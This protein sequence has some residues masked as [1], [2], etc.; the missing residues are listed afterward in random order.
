MH[1]LVQGEDV[2][3]SFLFWGG[4]LGRRFE[5]GVTLCGCKFKSGATIL[6]GVQVEIWDANMSMPI[7]IHGECMCAC[8]PLW[9]YVCAVFRC[10]DIYDVICN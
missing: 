1:T 9:R 6:F 10:D 5:S 3:V 4:H 8:F 2:R 7:L